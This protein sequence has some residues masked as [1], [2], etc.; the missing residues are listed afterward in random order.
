MNNRRIAQL[1][2]L[3]A[4]ACLPGQ[5][6]AMVFKPEKGAM[7]DPSVLWHD[8]KYLGE[9]FKPGQGLVLEGKIKARTLASGG[10]NRPTAGFVVGENDGQAMAVQLGI[11]QPD[12]R[13]THIG[14]LATGPD[15]T[16]TFTSED[17]TGKGCATVTGIEDGKEHAFRLLCRMEML[18]LYM[19]DLL[20]QTYIHAPGSGKVGFLVCNAQAGFSDQRA[21]SMSFAE[22]KTDKTLVSWVTLA[23]TTQQGG[24]ALTLQN[25]MT[26]DGIVFGEMEPGKWM[27]GSDYFLRSQ[28]DQQAN[29]AEK[30]DVKALVQMAIVY[31]DDRISLYRNGGLYVSYAANNIDLLKDKD[32]LAVFGLRHQGAEN[33]RTLLGSIEDAR[34]YNRALTADEIRKLEPNKKSAVTPYA[35]WTFEPGQETDRMGRFPVNSLGNGVKI[36]DGRLV[37]GVEGAALIASARPVEVRPNPGAGTP[38]TAANPPLNYHAEGMYHWDTWFLPLGDSVHM[39]HLQVKRPGSQRP[40]AD[41]EAV[42]HAVSKDLIHW[43][44][45]SVALRKGPPGSYDDGCLFTAYAVEHEGTIYLYYCSNHQENGR[46]RQGICL[47]TSKDSGRTYEKCAGNPIIEPDPKRYYAISEP[48]PP[49]GHHAHPHI[50]CRDLAIVKDPA[51]NGWLGYVVMRRKGQQDAFHSAC[52]AL[53]RSKDLVRWEIGDPVCTPNRFNCFEV[54]DVFKLGDKW[55]MIALTGDGYGQT[56]RWSDPEITCATVV[57]EADRPEGPFEEVKAGART[58]KPVGDGL[59]SSELRFVPPE[60]ERLYGMGENAVNAPNK[61]NLKGCMIDLFQRHMK[62]VVPFVVSSAGYGFLWNNPS[63][64]KVEF[65]NNKTRWM[66]NG[67]KQLDYFITAGDSYADIM[68]NYADATGHA[69]EFPYWASGFWQCKLRYENQEQFLNVAREFKRRNLPL[70]VLVIDFLHWDITGNW[71]LDPKCWPDPKAMVKEMDEMGYRIMI[72]PWTLVDEKSENFAYMKEHGLFTGSISGKMDTVDFI[73]PKYQYDPTN[74]EAAKFLWSKWRQILMCRWTRR[75]P[76]NWNCTFPKPRI[77][78][79]SASNSTTAPRARRST[80]SHPSCNPR[81]FSSSSP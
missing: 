49:F 54:P 38:V 26:F 7:W 52:I 4:S 58:F 66:S 77:M 37:L 23:N 34:I 60:G 42:G 24:S 20:V 30:A 3:M 27:A 39:Y 70:S 33:G 25:G 13:E 74:P 21:W 14:R 16:H 69:P 32:N 57:F 29:A 10:T 55:Y 62:A 75:A 12:G 44:E 67:C 8:G 63:L 78:A 19:D 45:Q 71:R 59:F 65:G 64:G 48:P 18:E 81:C 28:R 11:G 61:V 79:S 76:I 56:Q 47:A 40:D 1:A 5:A 53:C 72:S 68:E 2:I 43:Q 51:G 73:G 6:S 46:G 31:Q 50:D 41:H 80:F 35:W 9:K 15:G 17:V 36:E 22:A